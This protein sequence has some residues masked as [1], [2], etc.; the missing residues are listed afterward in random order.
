MVKSDAPGTVSNEEG[1]PSSVP[2][3]DTVLKSPDSLTDGLRRAGQNLLQAKRL[4]QH[5]PVTHLQL[6]PI[7]KSVDCLLLTPG[8]HVAVITDKNGRAALACAK[9]RKHWQV[10]GWL[11]DTR[12]WLNLQRNEVPDNLLYD[13]Q[14]QYRPGYKAAGM[15]DAII[16][17]SWAHQ[18]FSDKKFDFN[19][20]VQAVKNLLDLLP[21]HGQLLIQDFALPENH[22]RFVVIEIEDDEAV[23][24]LIEFSRTARAHAPEALRG[25][26]IE[27]LGAERSGGQSFRLPLKWAVEFYHRW[28]MGIAVNAPYELTTLSLGQWVALVEQCGAR[29]TYRAPHNMNRYE[30]RNLQ[31]NLR[32]YDENDQIMPMPASSFTLVVEKISTSEPVLFYERRISIEKAQNILISG[33]RNRVTDE[34]R[35]IVEI[36]HHEDDVLP[37]YLDAMGELHVLICTN[38]ERPIINAV[39]R[40]T[41]NLDG[42]QWA[43][44][45]I[46]PLTIEHIPGDVVTG[47]VTSEMGKILGDAAC[48]IDTPTIAIEYY[49]APDYL[50]QRVCGIAVQLRLHDPETPLPPLQTPQG[51]VIDVLASDV[52]HAL[53]AGLIPDGKLEILIGTLMHSQGQEPP[54]LSNPLEGVEKNFRTKFVKDRREAVLPRSVKSGEHLMEFMSDSPTEN[55]RAVRSVFVED[56]I[57]THGRHISS[58]NEQDFIVSNKLSANTAVVIPVMRD[59]MGNLLMSGEPRHLPVPQRL[60]STEPL[61]HMPRISL[62][63]NLKTVDQARLFIAEQLKCDAEELY[64]LGPSFFLQPQLTAERVYP[65]LLFGP[66]KNHVWMRWFKPRGRLQP[67]LA[68]HVE[69]TTAVIEFSAMRALGEFYQGYKPELA[70]AKKAENRPQED[71]PMP[72]TPLI[73]IKPQI[74]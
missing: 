53:S 54:M 40:G 55:L 28:R 25:F 14:P 22:D 2:A 18:V 52:L 63:G 71:D 49:P 47:F 68:R 32:F 1:D 26:F 36:K 42:R 37:W 61:M 29:A 58:Y 51:R 5:D 56:Q 8:Q 21:E 4:L 46:E 74:N 33:I 34:K 24:A 23:E 3:P 66:A 48:D 10:T 35:D 11:P 20:L 13:K 38:V 70:P 44:Y 69:K 65:F 9:A 15:P 57:S 41:Y 30:A 62:P 39:P 60:G 72:M 6:H 45:L 17:A 73:A 43:G 67:L 31:G 16:A 59:P 19:E 12:S 27:P 50:Y 7:E 64:E